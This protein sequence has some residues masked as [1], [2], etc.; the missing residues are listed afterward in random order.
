MCDKRSDRFLELTRAICTCYVTIARSYVL[1]DQDVMSMKDSLSHARFTRY[2]ASAGG[3]DSRA[4]ELYQWNAL[5][6][7]SLYVYLQC[8]E[9]TFRNRVDAFLRWKYG[10]NAWP[11]DTT[12]AVRNLGRDEQRRLQ[13]AIT[14]QER[15]RK[16]SPASTTQLWLTSQLDFGSHYFLHPTER[17]TLGVTTCNASF[18]TTHNSIKR[19]PMRWA[20]GF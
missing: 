20:H 9:I 18:Q 14:R 1:N 11:Y 17:R 8:W 12:R 15:Q 3:D 13:D 7:Q 4:I 2:L 6:A 10:T 5:I 16:N 19:R